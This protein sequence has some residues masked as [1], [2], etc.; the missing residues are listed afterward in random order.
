MAHHNT[1]TAA[2]ETAVGDEGDVGDDAGTGDGGGDREH[3][4]HAGPTLRPLVADDQHITLADLALE[5]GLQC[6]LLL[7]EHPG[8]AAMLAEW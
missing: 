7:L 4:A 1:V 8:R 2:G 5:N 3:L 6:G